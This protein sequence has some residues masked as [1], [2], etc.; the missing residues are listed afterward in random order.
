MQEAKVRFLLTVAGLGRT[1]SV[2]SS[3][4]QRELVGEPLV[5]AVERSQLRWFGHAIDASRTL[6]LEVFQGPKA[7]PGLAGPIT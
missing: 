7:G 1:D 2:R 5:L 4:I 3:D 6:S